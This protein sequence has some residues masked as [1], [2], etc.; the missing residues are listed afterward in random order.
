MT[1]ALVEVKREAKNKTSE[2][3]CLTI[4]SDHKI[5]LV[6]SHRYRFIWTRKFY[7]PAGPVIF[8]STND[9]FQ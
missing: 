1:M 5:F 2:N 7:F 4:N 8:F 9:G 6:Y 3:V